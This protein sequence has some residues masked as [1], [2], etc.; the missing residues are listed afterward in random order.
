MTD[1]KSEAQ[2]FEELLES[3]KDGSE[4]CQFHLGKKYYYGDG[5]PK[6]KARACMWILLAKFNTHSGRD[7]HSFNLH[8][9]ILKEIHDGD[10][11]EVMDKLQNLFINGLLSNN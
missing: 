1:K 11:V 4:N 2:L 10:D 3:A 9:A 5:V 7:E 8:D 6:D